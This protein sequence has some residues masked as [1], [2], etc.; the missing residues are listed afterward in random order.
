M[1]RHL[2][3]NQFLRDSLVKLGE[4][5]FLRRAINHPHTAHGLDLAGLGILAAPH[6]ADKM[7]YK[8]T[9]HDI[10]NSEI[11]GLGTLAAGVGLEA[12]HVRQALKGLHR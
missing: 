2:E 6:V 1:G 9:K 7:G 8:S 10:A 3:A 12:H 4:A 11:L 5:S